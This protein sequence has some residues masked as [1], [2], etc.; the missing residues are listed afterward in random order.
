MQSALVDRSFSK[1]RGYAGDYWTI[2]LFYQDQAQGAGPTA[3]SST[4]GS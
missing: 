4:V 1:P 3:A 2:E